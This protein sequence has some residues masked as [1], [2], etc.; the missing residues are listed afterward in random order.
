MSTLLPTDDNNNPIPAL[1][2]KS[3][4][5]A[6]N[7]A[8]TATS[9]KNTTAFANDTQVISVYATEPVF[10]KFGTSSVTANNTDHYFPA[11]VYYDMAIGGDGQA[12]ATHLA[13]IRA[14]NTDGVVYI[15]EKI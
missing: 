8:A 15:S 2:L 9:T 3:P 7:I 13:V 4:G 10:I 1:R 11:G 12:Q 5:G 14:E 6:H